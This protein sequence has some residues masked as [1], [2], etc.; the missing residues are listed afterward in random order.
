MQLQSLLTEQPAGSFH[1]SP[2]TTAC[3]YA[4]IALQQYLLESFG[5][6]ID[7]NQNG[8]G[9]PPLI[10]AASRSSAAECWQVIGLLLQHGADINTVNAK[11]ETAL[12]TVTKRGDLHS[13]RSLL[14]RNARH[15]I[16]S[17]ES[18]YAPVSIAASRDFLEGF[19]EL[20]QRDMLQ[21]V[22]VRDSH[23]N[24]I[25]G[26]CAAMGSEQVTAWIISNLPQIREVTGANPLEIGDNH[27]DT[28]LHRAAG[29]GNIQIMTMLLDAGAPI[30]ARNNSGQT[31][32]M[33]SKRYGRNS[34]ASFLLQRGACADP[35]LEGNQ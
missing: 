23:G 2:F 5:G 13:M 34:S 29:C 35:S 11:N 20:V 4:S 3:G 1:V 15:D 16:A 18:G 12:F 22:N 8:A 6:V 14:Q 26:T 21:L 25:L 31:A 10:A 27:G 17:S 30:N 24:S 19:Q 32:Y 9:Q 7:V 28:P 33:F